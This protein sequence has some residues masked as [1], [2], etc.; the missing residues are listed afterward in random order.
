M[1]NTASTIFQ[2]SAY[3]FVRTGSMWTEQKKLTASDGAAGDNFGT[4]VS[5]SGDTA[6]IGAGY[7]DVGA[8]SGDQGSAYVFVRSGIAWSGLK[9]LAE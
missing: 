4:S 6:V 8:S 9:L 1:D 5:V 2:G 7:D 3:V